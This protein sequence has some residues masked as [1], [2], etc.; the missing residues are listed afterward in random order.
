[1]RTIRVKI[2]GITSKQ[3]LI[4]AVD[5]GTDAVGFVV[6]TPSSPRNL[7]F[8]VAERLLRRVP[9]FVERIIVTVPENLDSLKR[10]YHRLKPDGIQIHG[11]RFPEAQ[12]IRETISHTR[13]I[14]AIHPERDEV[15]KSSL[16][17]LESFDAILLDSYTKE[18]PG[19]TGII[20]DWG[21]SRRIR[22]LVSPMPLILAG[23]LTCS[24]VEEA[25]RTV[26]PYAVDVSSGVEQSLGVKD[27]KK[28]LEFITTAKKV[29]Y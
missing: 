22:D 21:L 10:I 26:H 3:D 15:T 16:R 13:L 9:I 24:N 29:R 27:P 19:G 18:K 20:H 2:C 8:D 28:I 17:T 4:S 7:T 14:K 23:G 11:E 12:L 6:D 1:M 5:G 25:I